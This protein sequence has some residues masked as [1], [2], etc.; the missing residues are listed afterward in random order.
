[1]GT[2]FCHTESTMKTLLFIP[3]TLVLAASSEYRLYTAAKRASQNNDG[4]AESVLF[5]KMEKQ[6]SLDKDSITIL[7]WWDRRKDW[8][9]GDFLGPFQK[10]E[11]LPD[12][13]GG[14]YFTNDRSQEK[15]ADALLVDE[16][17]WLFSRSPTN[18]DNGYE[19][20]QPDLIDRNADQYWIVWFREA[21]SKGLNKIEKLNGPIDSAFNLTTSYRRD[22]DI[23]RVFGTANK[24]ILR[25]RYREVVETDENGDEQIKYIKLQTGEENIAAIMNQK[26]ENSA[27]TT[28][29]VSNCDE[30]RG[31]SM[32]LE[33]AQRLIQAGLSFDGYGQ[34]FNN[35]LLENS[36]GQGLVP[37]VYGTLK[38]DVE[39][40]APPN[41]Y[42]HVDDFDSPK[43]LVNYLDY[44]A[45]NQTAYE[46]YHQWRLTEPTNLDEYQPLSTDTEMTCGICKELR[47]RRQAGNP[48]RTY[49]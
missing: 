3:L 1:M 27:S 18:T 42:I 9:Q 24:A 36:L 14:C 23:P 21:A 19:R 28:W 41:S 31:A 22:A 15:T 37:V 43:A 45:K 40:V 39:A 26:K 16:T 29:L 30:T 34:C 44:L 8:V 13:C 48:K 35:T 2:H 6:R 12:Q 4:K 20:S 7:N 49:K 47:K 17:R 46:E 10:T 33:F 32:R 11:K 38:E 25:A 5:A